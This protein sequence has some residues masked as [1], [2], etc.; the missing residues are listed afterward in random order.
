MTDHVVIGAAAIHFGRLFVARRTTPTEAAGYWEL[1]GDEQRSG[2]DDSETLHR[3]FTEEFSRSLSLRT[4]RILP[5]R[6]IGAWRM[7]GG[8]SVQANLQTVRCSI[9]DLLPED[10][11][12]GVP[13]ANRYCYDESFWVPVDDLD[14]IGPWRHADRMMADDI[15]G[16]YYADS[17]WHHH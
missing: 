5:E 13:H 9:A 7:T 17:N 15:V 12:H 8:N 16:Y 10:V 2:E 6:L 4:E 3:V 14:L 1:P 11:Y